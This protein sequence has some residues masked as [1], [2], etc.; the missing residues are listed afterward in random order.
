MD[1]R[2][3]AGPDGLHP[4]FLKRLPEAALLVVVR[5]FKLS[6][7]STVV[8]QCWRVGEIVPMLKAGKDPADMG[9]TGRCV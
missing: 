3:A 9:S 1:E 8:P 6:V 5:L 2:K 7:R 4:R